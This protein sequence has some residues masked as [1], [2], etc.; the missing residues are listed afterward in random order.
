MAKDKIETLED[1]FREEATEVSD[2]LA[3]EV[4]SL[5]ELEDSKIPEALTSVLRHAHNLKGAACTAGFEGVEKLAHALEDSLGPSKKDYALLRDMEFMGAIHN[6]IAFLQASIMSEPDKEI[7]D[8]VIEMLP[9]P[10]EEPPEPVGA[11]QSAPESAPEPEPEPAPEPE[12]KPKSKT[13]AKTKTKAKAKA[14]A[15]VKTASQSKAKPEKDGTDPIQS[16]RIESHKLNHLMSFAGDLLVARARF[17]ARFK[18][19]K[20]LVKEVTRHSKSESEESYIFSTLSTRAKTLLHRYRQDIS[21]FSYLTDELN[22]A[23]KSTRMMPLVSD[24]A[25]WRRIVRDSAMRTAK[26]VKLDIKIGQIEIDKF[27]LENLRDPMMHILRNAV[28]HGIEESEERSQKG[29][30]GRGRIQINGQVVGTSIRLEISDDGRGIHLDRVG[31]IAIKKGLISQED[32]QNRSDIEKRNL[33]FTPGFSTASEVSALSGRGVGMDVVRTRIESLGGTVQI[34]PH[35]V[36]G[37]TTFILDI[38]SNVLSTIGLMVNS[39]QS[40]YAIPIDSIQRTLS[41]KKEDIQS[42]SGKPTVRLENG[43]P[44]RLAWLEEAM[45]ESSK[46]NLSKNKKLLVVLLARGESLL[47]LVTDEILGESEFV[48]RELPWN[49]KN[50]NTSSVAGVNGAVIQADGS[51]AVSVDVPWIFE[52]AQG[53]SAPREERAAPSPVIAKA[54]GGKKHILV[55]DDS[56]TVRTMERNLFESAGYEVTLASDGE[57]AWITVAQAEFDLVVSDI[58]MPHSNGI[59]LTRRIRSDNRFRDLPIILVSSLRRAE[60]IEAGLKAGAD[61]YVVKGSFDQQSLLEIVNK[62]L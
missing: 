60:D 46:N 15:K 35:S 37:G 36:L 62:Y 32:Y 10:K 58:D 41:I 7:I 53:A 29:K 43:E 26:T 16:I 44:I 49:M 13:K 56:L 51:L 2:K 50:G 22:A 19:L 4:E 12:P 25:F 45:Q 17:D 28:D 59:E 38:P 55:V 39:G 30:D 14:K 42:V 6:A 8:A 5:E 20:D 1:I 52:W 57:E 47:G 21:D 54:G 31:E 24:D 40:T 9:I 48:V 61:E 33:I 18:E 27:V 23:M 34:A 3:R 11:E